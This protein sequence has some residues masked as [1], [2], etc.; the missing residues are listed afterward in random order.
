M[1]CVSRWAINNN[2]IFSCD[3][4][5]EVS[6]FHAAGAVSL[7]AVERVEGAGRKRACR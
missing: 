5:S 3:E 6:A 4:Q 2:L 7:R 1:P